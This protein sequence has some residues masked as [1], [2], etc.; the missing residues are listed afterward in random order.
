MLV[1]KWGKREDAFS[2]GLAL[3]AQAEAVSSIHGQRAQE[4]VQSALPSQEMWCSYGAPFPMFAWPTLMMKSPSD[5]K[6]HESAVPKSVLLA[7]GGHR[8]E[9][10]CCETEQSEQIVTSGSAGKGLP[11]LG[12]AARAASTTA[13]T[14]AHG[15]TI[16][17]GSSGLGFLL[18]S[19]LLPK[20]GFES[21]W[22]SILLISISDDF[23]PE[24]QQQIKENKMLDLHIL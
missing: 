16:P 4:A 5:A 14:A 11:H 17:R 21:R 1:M 7:S 23:V 6:L 12:W 2:T 19:L 3:L 18:I 24:A 10:L 8:S 20:K 22:C 15:F 13:S 9:Q